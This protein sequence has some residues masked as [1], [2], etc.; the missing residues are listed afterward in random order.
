MLSKS[1]F[2]ALLKD[3][4]IKIPEQNYKDKLFNRQ[5]IKTSR[6]NLLR[7]LALDKNNAQEISNLVKNNKDELN[8]QSINIV[9]Q[10]AS[11]HKSSVLIELD[12][13]VFFKQAI[14]NINQEYWST[15]KKEVLEDNLEMT[16]RV[17]IDFS[18]PNIA[19]PFHFGHLKSTLL[20]NYLSNLNSFL[21]NQVTKLNYIGDWGTQY[22]LLSLGLD[23]FSGLE[24]CETR[25]SVRY[26]L[27]IYIKANERAKLD[28]S[29]F[30]E[31]KKNFMAMDKDEN[32]EL[33]D[34]WR[35]IRDLSL[36]ELMNSYA[37][38]GISFDNFE[39]ES[40]YAKDS[41]ALVE[42]IKSESFVR[43]L[44][45]GVVVAQVKKNERFFDV[46]LLKS[47]GTSLYLT[48][49]IV[50]AISREKK[51]NFDKMLYIVGTDQEKHFHCLKEILKSMKYLWSDKLIHVK[52]GKVLGMSSRSGNFVLLSDIIEEATKRYIETTKDTP[53]SKVVS[54]EEIANVGKHLALS[55][56]FVYDLSKP[57]TKHYEFDWNLVMTNSDRSGINLQTTFARL[58]SLLEKASSLG[59]KP[60]NYDEEI[61]LSVTSSTEAQNLASHLEELDTALYSSFWSLDPHYLT[62]HALRLCKAINRARRSEKL[63]VIDE[64]D[65]R[66]ARTKLS[67]FKSA[68][69]QLEFIIKLLGLKP[70]Y[71]V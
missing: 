5:L 8:V 32:T 69:I 57:R 39:Y 44:E 58:A 38:L 61:H 66:L 27:D 47:D 41:V 42:S 36:K 34:R 12:P 30:I 60:M 67:L 31:A 55:A 49:D 15:I 1:K 65:E 23:E 35:R 16:E 64:Q 11:S 37:Q 21:G 3:V 18:S 53:T 14:S 46:P 43:C 68:H 26:L 20:G 19:K 63:R 62:N 45:D 29:F 59:L 28:Q 22:G 52:V 48:R 17:V 71:K 10:P 70:L 56:L 13:K 25:P 33:L 51:Y 54:G 9:D 4:L 40:S 7:V 2:R 6:G 24:N 50:A